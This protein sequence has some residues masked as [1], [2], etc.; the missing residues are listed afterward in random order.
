MRA[1][2]IALLTAACILGSSVSVVAEETEDY[3]YLEDMS[4]KELKALRDAINEILGDGG[5]SDNNEASASPTEIDLSELSDI[6]LAALTM[7]A[8]EDAMVD[9]YG[10]EYNEVTIEETDKYKQVTIVLHAPTPAGNMTI[11]Y[12]IG[13]VESVEDIY[14]SFRYIDHPCLDGKLIWLNIEQDSAFAPDSDDVRRDLEETKA[15]RDA[16]LKQG[17]YRIFDGEDYTEL[18]TPPNSETK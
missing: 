15:V 2:V 8:G 10:I 4:V 18:S 9:R 11:G 17:A 6:N 12:F 13:Q 16:F 5:T 3:S 14:D 1:R 7:I